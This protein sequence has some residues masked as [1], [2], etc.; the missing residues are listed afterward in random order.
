LEGYGKQAVSDEVRLEILGRYG[1]HLIMA[2][3]P[4]QHLFAEHFSRL[5]MG[6]LLTPRWT[7][8]GI[9]SQGDINAVVDKKAGL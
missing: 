3:D 1:I 7:P 9:H 5:V 2:G 6:R 4:D 8:V